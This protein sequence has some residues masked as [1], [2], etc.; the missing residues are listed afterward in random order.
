MTI[1]KECPTMFTLALDG[2]KGITTRLEAPL[3]EAMATC[4]NPQRLVVCLLF[5]SDLPDSAHTLAEIERN[6]IRIFP[7]S[8]TYQL[9]P[10]AYKDFAASVIRFNFNA[11]T[12]AV[13]A[14]VLPES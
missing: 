1:G 3:Y 10:D 7:P 13:K 8:L 4:S 5:M 2:L 9:T 6:L 11:E 12:S 14:G